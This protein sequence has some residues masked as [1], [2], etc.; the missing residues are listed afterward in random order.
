MNADL[1][2]VKEN[3]DRSTNSAVTAMLKWRLPPV[4]DYNRLATSDE[5]RIR[6]RL[7]ADS[8]DIKTDFVSFLETE[9]SL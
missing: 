2:G 9:S 3:N 7:G 6:T 5:S 4:D 1:D 8:I